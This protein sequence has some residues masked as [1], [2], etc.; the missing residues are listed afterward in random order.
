MDEIYEK[1]YSSEDTSYKKYIKDNF[2][3]I[4]NLKFYLKYNP[5]YDLMS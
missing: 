4:I 2:F 3:D 5:N 1:Y